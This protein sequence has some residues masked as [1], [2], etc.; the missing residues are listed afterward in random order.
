LIGGPSGVCVLFSG[1]EFYP[2]SDTEDT[3]TDTL[4]SGIASRSSARN[5]LTRS[6][7]VRRRSYVPS[8]GSL[9]M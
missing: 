4:S 3:G 8:P 7:R 9:A 2:V 6:S 1:L 5:K